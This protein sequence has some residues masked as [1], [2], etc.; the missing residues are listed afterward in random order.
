MIVTSDSFKKISKVNELYVFL[1]YNY[2]D[3]FVHLSY[4]PSYEEFCEIEKLF[5]V[6]GSMFIIGDEVSVVEDATATGLGIS[7]EDVEDA[8]LDI[9]EEAEEDGYEY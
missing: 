9:Q 5:N 6:V 3:Q 4:T 1:V 8:I 2:K 7:V